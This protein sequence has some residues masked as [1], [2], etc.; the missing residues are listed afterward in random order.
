MFQYVSLVGLM[1]AVLLRFAFAQP[2]PV[3]RSYDEAG[4]Y[5]GRSEQQDRVTRYYDAEGRLRGRDERSGDGVVRQY[6]KDGK[7]IGTIRR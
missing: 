1:M 2:Q 4:R 6:D 5:Q 3:Q 7:L